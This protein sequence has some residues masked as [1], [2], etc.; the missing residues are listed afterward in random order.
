MLKIADFGIAKI[1]L[2]PE[3]KSNIGT[4]KYWSPEIHKGLKYNKNSDVW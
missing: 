2:E 1:L 4:E 3:T